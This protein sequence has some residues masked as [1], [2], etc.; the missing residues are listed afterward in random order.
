MLRGRQD[1]QVSLGQRG[2]PAPPARPDPRGRR[3]SPDQPVRK[4]IPGPL[5][6]RAKWDLRD[7]LARKDL[8]GPKVQPAPPVLRVRKVHK[9]LWARRGRKG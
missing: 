7:L 1:R 2:L 5:D 3:E 6:R 4:V 9:D 8:P